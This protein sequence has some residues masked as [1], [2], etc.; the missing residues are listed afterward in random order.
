MAKG[1]SGASLSDLTSAMSLSATSIYAAFGSKEGLFL[2]A[3]S[4]YKECGFVKVWGALETAP[5]ARHGIEAMLIASARLFNE[6][7]RPAGCL[8]TLGTIEGAADPGVTRITKEL[9]QETRQLIEKRLKRG[10]LDG[11]IGEGVDCWMLASFF[12]TVQQGMA[13][14]A[15]D[16][17]SQTTLESNALAG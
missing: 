5:T 2:D 11:E 17:G 3:L 16:G 15:Q 10:Q 1:F 14:Q 13:I 8:I 7:G 9:R 4:L 12:M 6:P